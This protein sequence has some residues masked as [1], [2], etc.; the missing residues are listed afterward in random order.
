M[1][2]YLVLMVYRIPHGDRRKDVIYRLKVLLPIKAVYPVEYS[3]HRLHRERERKRKSSVQLEGMGDITHL[4]R[5]F[6]S[7][8]LQMHAFDI[9][10]TGSSI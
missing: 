7:S 6:V 3:R 8:S 4:L 5:S 10:S 2:D 1:I 9:P